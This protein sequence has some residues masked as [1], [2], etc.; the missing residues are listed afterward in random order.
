MSHPF[1]D[2]LSQYLHRKHGL[3]QFKLADGID[4][5]PSVISEMCQGKRLH[6]PQARERVVAIISWL[7][8]QA[9]LETLEEANALLDAAGMSPLHDRNANEAALLRVLRVQAKH[10]PLTPVG[11]P[12][13]SS[14]ESHIKGQRSDAAPRYNLPSQPTLFIG[15]ENELSEIIGRITDRHC[16]LLVLVGPGGIGKT[17]LALKAVQILIDAYRNEGPFAHGILFI[18]LVAVSSTSEILSA[19]AE[20]AAFSFYS[21]VP[22]Q[23]QLLDY[24]REKEMLL[25]LD[26]FE[27][28]L[29]AVAGDQG[30]TELIAEI[31]TAAPRIKILVTSRED[32]NLQEAWLHPVQG[33]AFPPLSQ[34]QFTNPIGQGT[35]TAAPIEFRDFDAVQ[36]FWQSARRIQVGF[37]LDRELEHVIRICQL[38]EGMPLGIELA[39][40]WLKVIPAGKIAD[41]IERGLDILSTRLQNMPQRHR[42]MR[43]VFEHSWQLLAEEERDV[44][45]RLSVF[46]GSF[47]REAAQ[48]IAG[49]TLLTLASLIEKSLVQT[50]T[51]GRYRMHELLHQ[52]ARL[53]LAQDEDEERTTCERQ[54]GYYL[55]LLKACEVRL[56]SQ[57]QQK[58]LDEIGLEI[59]NILVG[60]RWAVEQS[61]IETID[62]LVEALYNFYLIRG[63]YSEGEEIF[64]QTLAQLELARPFGPAHIIE[65]VMNRLTARLGAFLFFA[66]NYEAA[67][68]HLL[69]SLPVARQPDERAF[70]LTMLGEVA[71]AQ[72]RPAIAEEWLLN[73][74]AICRETGDPFSLAQS[75]KGLAGLKSNLGDYSAAVQLASESLALSRQLGRPDLVAHALETLAWPTNCLGAYRESEAYW[76]ECLAIYEKNGNQW[77]VALSLNLLGWVV[78][79]IG[80][81]VMDATIDQYQQALTIYRELGDRKDIAMSCGD[82]GLA[83]C[84]LGNYEQA[85]QYGREGLK[86]AQ[87]IGINAFVIYNLYIL[88]AAACG[89]G[90]FQASRNYLLQALKMARETENHA[91]AMNILFFFASLLL[92]ESHNAAGPEPS[93]H[94]QRFKALELLAFVI[95]RPETWQPIRD[96]AARLLAEAEAELAGDLTTIAKARGQRRTMEEV[97]TELLQTG[98]AAPIL[99]AGMTLAGKGWLG[100]TLH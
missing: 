90:D 85:V 10:S 31:L 8:L 14:V 34:P 94:P 63:R 43:A 83:A 50:T 71:E 84:E 15:R 23:Q 37:T 66:G 2:L 47:T 1:G 39:A 72:S 52:F 24:L 11:G 73:S 5:T 20:A 38:V 67:S 74:L 58:A 25:V 27:H 95:A 61:R 22:P 7:Q 87:E 59:D 88:G 40:S 6:G 3:S 49:A 96:R 92:K 30:G 65:D 78:Y 18:P 48:Q 75:L 82:L 46:R 35:L 51:S 54:S 26:N 89:Q 4:Q 77:G 55:N 29:G 16:R 9:A 86:T 64:A 36:L 81:F 56:T 45:Q 70:V 12:L 28:L 60:W 98:Q 99:Q 41:E 53:K 79:C 44:F 21:N 76:Q 57:E 69:E 68:R 80:G 93:G 62:Q 33:L 17:R 91:H 32:L 13:I 97:V 19:I 42:S 100:F